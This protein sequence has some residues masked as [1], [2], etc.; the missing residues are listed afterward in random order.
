MLLAVLLDRNLNAL[1]DELQCAVR[2]VASMHLVTDAIGREASRSGAACT[3]DRERYAI[4]H[5][6]VFKNVIALSYSRKTGEPILDRRRLSAI[7]LRWDSPHE[8]QP[9]TRFDVCF[10]RYLQSQ[11][12]APYHGMLLLQPHPELAQAG[13]IVHTPEHLWS[14]TKVLGKPSIFQAP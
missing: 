1:S 3:K 14:E 13:Q 4:S 7:I 5:C 10:H 9:V 2:G 8:P 12:H 11:L 6:D